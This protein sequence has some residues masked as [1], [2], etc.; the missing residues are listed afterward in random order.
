MFGRQ[1]Y[2]RGILRQAVAERRDWYFGDHGY[3]RRGLYFRVARGELQC[4]GRS[5]RSSTSRLDRLGL[6]IEPWRDAGDRVVVCPPSPEFAH[7]EGFSERLWLENVVRLIGDQTSRPVLIRS[8]RRAASV[9]LGDDLDNAW[10]LVTHNSN[11]AVEALIAG[12][13]VFVSDKCAA[14][15]LAGHW[16]DIENPNRSGDRMAWAAVLAANQW[17]L[18]EI[19]DGT[20]WRDLSHPFG[21]S[22]RAACG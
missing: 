14:R 6:K 17:T 21:E 15:P 13:P 19:G 22:S 11:A 9:A 16:L 4:S 1:G 10:C 18:D 5:T 2:L 20:C 3:F 8:R 12:V 7:Q